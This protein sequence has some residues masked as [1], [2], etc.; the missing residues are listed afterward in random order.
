MSMMNKVFAI[1]VTLT[2][3]C[4]A[5]AAT[6]SVSTFDAGSYNSTFNTQG[7]RGENFEA[8]GSTRGEGE[9]GASLLTTVGTFASLGGNGTGGSVIGSGTQLALR[10]GSVYGR[11]NTAPKGGT[12][13]LDTNDTWGINWVVDI[14]RMFNKVAFV[15]NDASD[16]GAFLRIN[17]GGQAQEL[18]TGGGLANGNALAILIDFGQAVSTAQITLG[19]Y[20]RSGGNT[21]KLNDGFSIDG[22]QVAPVPLPASMLLLGAA[23]GGL[24]WIGRRK[25]R[26]T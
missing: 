21:Y 18:R 25:V 10:D 9:V 1:A 16:A 19:N 8:L 5:N 26:T 14:G 23:I 7:S 2:C 13:F 17:A 24:G 4:T 3:A 6:I 15:L 12:W 11:T 22:I 20:S